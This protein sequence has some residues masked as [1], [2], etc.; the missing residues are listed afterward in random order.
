MAPGMA[1][2]GPA[3]AP[4]G[5]PTT[6]LTP[7]V[8]PVIAPVIA[9]AIAPVPAADDVTGGV[10][11]VELEEPVAPTL[12]DAPS[13]VETDTA[14]R[15]ADLQGVSEVTSGSRLVGATAA[16]AIFSAAVLLL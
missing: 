2:T 6:A 5:G 8:A 16:A 9:P 7:A 14:T 4:A 3:I 1:S 13:P 10:P 15:E 12:D 11:P